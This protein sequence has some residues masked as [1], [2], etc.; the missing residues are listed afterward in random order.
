VT[1]RAFAGPLCRYYERGG[2]VVRLRAGVEAWRTDLR[3]AVAAKVAAQLAWD[4]GSPVAAWHDLGASGWLALRLFAFYADHTELEMPDTVPAL[5]ELDA[6][7]RQAQDGKFARSHYGQLL[8]CRLWL[9]G[10]FP[11]TL[12]V[13]LPDGETAEVGSLT[14]LADQLRWLNQRTFQADAEQI[15]NWAALPAEPGGDLL[16][17]ARRGYFGLA[18]AVREAVAARVPVVVQEV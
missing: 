6:A 18:A 11:V 7:W 4:E 10:D 5:L 8:A 17:A 1:A 3:G 12:R 9:P 16:A 15:A 14:V 13:P 2:D